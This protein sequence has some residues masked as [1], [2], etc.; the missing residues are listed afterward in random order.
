MDQRRVLLAVSGGIAAY[1]VPELV[2]AL[3]ADGHEVRCAL[4]RSAAEFVSPLALQTVSGSRVRAELFDA[5]EEGEI[6]HIA[7][8]DWADL[9]VV[10][11][12][13]AHV[14]ARMA[15]GL[16]DDLV[17]TLLLATRAPVLVAP[18]MNVNM[19]AHPATRANVECL[20]GRGVLFVGPAS[21]P[22]A[23]GW[24]GEGRMAEP[25]E[26]AAA[27]RLALGPASLAGRSVVVTAGGT[28]E[29]LDAVRA[30]TN[31]SS[32]KMGFAVAA[33]AAR[34]GAEV[35]L[36]AGP[37]GLPT[38][39]GVRRVDVETALEMREAV[40]AELPRADALVMAAAVADFRP[41]ERAEHKIK[42]EDLPGDAAPTLALVR[43][44]DILAEAS[45]RPGRGVVVGFAAESRD[46]LAAARRKLERKGCDLLVANDVSR[47]DAGFDSD[48]NAVSF[49]WPGGDVEEL[50]LLSKTEVAARLWDRVEKL[51]GSGA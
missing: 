9:V 1:K 19:W 45:R 33:E 23:C 11:P 8:A 30:L 28:R 43:N 38:P 32:G 49:V 36:V 10:A 50:P 41:A 18:A 14:L 31:R 34:R 20:R 40:F 35:V 25:A 47:A 12:A 26:I 4:T 17:T 3:R 2:R 37:G 5:E 42:K 7:L 24:E 21:G 48:S 16:A 13:T 44:P 15:H 39:A 46:V 29:P 27:V 6:D 22:L 51:L